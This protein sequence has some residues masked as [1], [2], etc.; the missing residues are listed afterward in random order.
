[1]RWGLHMGRLW[2][3]V[4]GLCRLSSAA[5]APGAYNPILEMAHMPEALPTIPL[6]MSCK[7][8]A[9]SVR[10]VA[11]WVSWKSTWGSGLANTYCPFSADGQ[12]STHIKWC[13]LF[14]QDI[15]GPISPHDGSNLP[16]HGRKRK[17]VWH[18]PGPRVE[19]VFSIK[20]SIFE[21]KKPWDAD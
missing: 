20:A 16:N 12:T 1:M 15:C 18:A 14:H 21:E 7:S 17:L 8:P 11:L 6:M 3:G 2:L 5:I 19:R 9:K 13:A 4:S 10:M